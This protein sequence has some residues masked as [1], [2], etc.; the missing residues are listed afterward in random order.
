[1]LRRKAGKVEWLEFELLQ[2]FPQVQH[3]IFLRHGGVSSGAYS[4]LN[5]NIKGKDHKE[6][7]AKNLALIRD[8]LS[9]PS[10]TLCQQPHLAN[11]AFLPKTT[12][13]ELDIC[14]GMI[15]NRSEEALLIGH[16]DCQ[17]ALFFDPIT[18][19]IANVHAGWRGNVQNIYQAT[20]EKLK[21]STGAK[22]ENLRVCIS[23]SLGPD[24]AEFIHFRA[25]LPESFW[26]FQIRPTYFNLWEISRHQLLEAGVLPQHIQIAGI[27]TYDNP[28]DFF[29]F[30]RDKRV[31]GGHATV[32]VLRK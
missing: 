1:M 29:S 21:I 28:H 16:A 8:A 15:T 12:Q 2:P 19:T 30:R 10:L 32:I 23:P 27:C 4:S 26:P 7:I 18:S 25:E 11:V 3:G 20:I 5:T 9:V 6:N 24:R 13:A 31:T 22:V 17:A 14:D